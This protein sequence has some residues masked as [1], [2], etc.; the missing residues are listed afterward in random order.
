MGRIS[1]FVTLCPE[2]AILTGL[3]VGAE[4]LRR[5]DTVEIEVLGI[6]TEQS[7]GLNSWFTEL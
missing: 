5:L 2:D 4:L 6:S 1:K 7:C 3:P